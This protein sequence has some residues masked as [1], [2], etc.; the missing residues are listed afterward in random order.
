MK[1]IIFN[2]K[3]KKYFSNF[4]VQ[5]FEGMGHGHGACTHYELIV[6]YNKIYSGLKIKFAPKSKRGTFCKKV[7]LPHN[8]FSKKFS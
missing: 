2:V 3:V 6:R 8:L 5:V 1:L 4:S 7:P